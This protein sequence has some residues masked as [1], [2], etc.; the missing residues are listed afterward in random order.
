MSG[1]QHDIFKLIQKVQRLEGALAIALERIK[2][3]EF[4]AQV[5]RTDVTTGNDLQAQTAITAVGPS[6]CD[7]SKRS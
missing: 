3:L 1:E 4:D 2:R 7:N 5:R 6:S